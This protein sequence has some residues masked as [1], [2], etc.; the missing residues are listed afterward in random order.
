MQAEMASIKSN[1]TW[2]LVP[3][4]PGKKE[5]SSKWVYK[6]KTGTPGHPTR[7]KARL[8]A[9]GFEQKDDFLETFAPVVC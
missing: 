1:R 9:R 5:I 8:V 4:P 2:S 3:L 6:V 7:Y